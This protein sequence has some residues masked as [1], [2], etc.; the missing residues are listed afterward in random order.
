[1]DRKN[2]QPTITVEELE[3]RARELVTPIDFDA[4]IQAGVLEKHRAWYKILIMDK[5]P[6]HAK[7]KIYKIKTGD[8]GT[9]VQFREPSKRLAK[10]LEGRRGKG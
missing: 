8:K 2:R 9:L 5:L 6:A 4:L 7:A 10:M 1:M 3:E